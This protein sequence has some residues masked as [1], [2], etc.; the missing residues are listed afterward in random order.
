LRVRQRTMV[1]PTRH[2]DMPFGTRLLGDGR[3]R[4]RLWAPAASRV[5]LELET[6][7]ATGP[8]CLDMKHC[9]QGW[10]ELDTHHAGPG[11]R[12]RYAVDGRPPVPDPAS[13]F[14]PSDVHGA[15]EVVD[16]HAWR[17]SD[18]EWRGRPWN[19]CVFYEIHVGTFTA[20]GTFAGVRNKLE[21]LRSLGVTALQLMPIADFP[22]TRNWGY[23]GVY[24]YAPDSCYGRPEDLKALV[25]AAHGLG[26][27]IFLDVVYNHFGPEGNY[28]H[29]YAPDFF[30][31]DASTPWGEAIAY[32]GPGAAPVRDFMIHNAL[33]WLEEYHFDGL[34]LDAVH[35]IH[36]SSQPDILT[37][38]AQRV[39]TQLPADRQIHLVLEND[40]NQARY[41]ARETDGA[42]GLY[43]AQWNDDTHHALHVILTGETGGYYRD[44]AKDPV[45]HLIRCLTEGFAYQGECSDYRDGQP[46]GEFSAHLPATAFVN[47]LQNHDQVGNR[48]FGERITVLAP[49]AAIRAAVTLLLLHPAIPLLFMGQEWGARKPFPYFCD[50]EPALARQVAQG[51]RREF[52]AFEAF[53]DPASINRLPDPGAPATFALAALDW[54]RAGSGDGKDLLALHRHLLQLRQRYLLPRMGRPGPIPL[55]Q[56]RLAS[57]AFRIGW[58]LADDS[59]L[60]VLANLTERRVAAVERP[61]GLALTETGPG[62]STPDQRLQLPP[63]SVTWFLH[64]P[65]ES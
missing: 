64:Q 65:A 46:R 34:R 27:M 43:S 53:R 24:L 62:T 31:R 28:L 49:E 48:A 4:F 29:Q 33:F 45:G 51:R 22:G 57:G 47:F 61:P 38:L 55:E 6:P 50:F 3:V 40:R 16:P 8:L 23:D 30:T 41:L 12:Y 42:T 52:S 21:Y 25:E 32:Q 56:E 63:W 10:Y 58:R 14:Q 35:S 5:V 36:D 20:D 59:R 44:Y 13:R 1:N 60:T 39:R 26:L 15:S 9:G 7:G 11:T 54:H 17:W 19:S 2:H 37:E 18:A